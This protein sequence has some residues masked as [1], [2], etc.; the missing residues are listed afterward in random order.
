MEKFNRDIRAIR[1]EAVNITNLSIDSSRTNHNL[2]DFRKKNTK[3][4]KLDRYDN[5]IVLSSPLYK[6]MFRHLVDSETIKDMTNIKFMNQYAKARLERKRIKKQNKRISKEHFV[7]NSNMKEIR[8]QS[9]SSILSFRKSIRVA[10]IRLKKY[11]KAC[12]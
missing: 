5:R 10:S 7:K 6:G 3:K 11:E 1:R 2:I 12:K 9:G 4:G 8:F